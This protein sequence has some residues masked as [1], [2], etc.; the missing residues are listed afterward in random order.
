MQGKMRKRSITIVVVIILNMTLIMGVVFSVLAAFEN[1]RKVSFSQ[2]IENVRTLTNASANKVELELLHHTQELTYVGNYVNNYNGVGMSLEEIQ[3]YFKEYYL[4][5]EVSSWQLVEKTVDHAGT[6]GEA[7]PAISLCGEETEHFGYNAKAYPEL[8]RIFGIADEDTEGVIRYTSEFTD[9]SSGHGKSSAITTT[10]RVRNGNSYE[11]RTLMYLVGS[12]YINQLISSNNDVDSWNFFDYS[13]IIIDDEGKYVISNSYFQGTNFMKY[14]A[15]YNE[16]FSDEDADEICKKLQEEDYYDVLYYQN[17]KGEECAYTIVPVQDS[18]WHILSIVP[19]S[20]FH[21]TYDFSYDFLEF[22][23]VLAAL[24]VVDVLVVLITNR[25]LRQLTKEARQA[26]EAKSQFL[27]SMSHDIRT[28]MNAIIGMTVI[29]QKQLEEKNI[30][31]EAVKESIKTIGLSGNHLLH[32]IN[33]ILDITKIESGKAVLHLM[34]FSITEMIEKIVEIC[35][36]TVKEK[37]F[38][39]ETKFI[40]IRHKFVTGDSLRVNQ[41]FVNILSNA[42]KYTEP[43][44][45][46]TIELTEKAVAEQTDRAR[47]IYRVSDT[48]IGMSPEFVD[49]IFE[50]FTRAVDTRINTVEGTG[51]GMAIVKQLVTMLGG[52]VNV[53]SEENVGT[54]FTV[55]LEFSIAQ[56]IVKTETDKRNEI[57]KKDKFEDMRI[58]VAEDNETNWKVIRKI[59]SFYGVNPQRAKNGEVAVDMLQEAEDGYDIILMDI[60]MPVMN[61]YEATKRIRTL[62]DTKKASVAIYAMTADTFTEDI[63]KCEEAGMNG[64]L[65]KPIEVEKLVAVLRKISSGRHR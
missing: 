27:S 58:L 13:N 40:D 8:A 49:T 21:N 22:A 24:F 5:E 46:I 10:L 30:D 64:H 19:L 38:V 44:G 55:E 47:Y 48:G 2:N 52:S 54:V 20:S 33:D 16:D 36:P 60:Q 50:R 65:Q 41:I 43:G 18:N 35:Q 37:D 6:S 28:P 12:H 53:E 7:F 17:N 45:R 11:Y 26:N 4:P 34:D 39:V 42:L 25:R 57:V 29:A 31:R 23:L 63:K 56:E 32:L 61:G 3:D 51:L 14:I 9:S 59:L 15:L 62:S 1:S